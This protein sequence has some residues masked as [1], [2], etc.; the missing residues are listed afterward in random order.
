MKKYGLHG[1]LKAK[2]GHGEK[3]A[4]IRVLEKLNTNYRKEDPCNRIDE[5]VNF[6]IRK[7]DI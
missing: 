3:L 7:V 5:A 1:K 6:R 4:S 2:T